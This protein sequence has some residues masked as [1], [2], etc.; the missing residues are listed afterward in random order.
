MSGAWGSG[1]W[2]S[3]SWG[4][5]PG[6]P[7]IS[8]VDALPIRENVVRV[9]F[10]TKVYLSGLRE[11]TDASIVDKWAVTADTAALDSIGDP[12]RSVA[13]V[14]AVI[15]TE[16]VAEVDVGRFVELVLDRPMS[17]FPAQYTVF[18]SGIYAA[19]LATVDSGSA[20]IY[21]VYR[22]L[23]APTAIAAKPSRDFANP[24]LADAAREELRGSIAASSMGTFG[25][26]VDGD[27]AYDEGLASLR[28]RV[29]RRLVTKKGSFAHLPNY[30]VGVPQEA[31]RLGTTAVLSR[32]AA[33][34]ESQLAAEPDV[35]A[36]KVVTEMPSGS[37]G[38]VFFRVFVRQRSGNP[39][40][41]DVPFQRT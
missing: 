26:G 16:N 4:G 33:D 11:T 3:G 22:A 27:Y 6:F 21:A 9:E 28:K 31:K 36:V 40:R 39:V 38:L 19:D 29:I 8:F 35:A 1:G 32:L 7:G 25:V 14:A 37:P 23:Q 30:G 10:A 17:S 41:I 13:V 24:Q 15:A 18:W 20:K 12:S 5:G 34:A 2:G